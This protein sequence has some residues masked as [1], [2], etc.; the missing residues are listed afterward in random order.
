MRDGYH[1]NFMCSILQLRCKFLFPSRKVE[2]GE[3]D[4][5]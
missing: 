2:F 4:S 5:G 3:I 1:T